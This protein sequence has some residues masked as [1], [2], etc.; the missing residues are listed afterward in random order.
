MDHNIYYI[1]AEKNV[2]PIIFHNLVVCAQILT[3]QIQTQI[4]EYTNTSY[5]DCLKYQI[6]AIGRTFATTTDN[7]STA[8]GWANLKYNVNNIIRNS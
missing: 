4:Y 7:M 5:M 1:N 6:Y 8:F 2:S 3:I